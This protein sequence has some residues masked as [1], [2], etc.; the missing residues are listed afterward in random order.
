VLPTAL[1]SANPQTSFVSLYG[2]GSLIVQHSSFRSGRLWRMSVWMLAKTLREGH[3]C[4]WIGS[5]VLSGRRFRTFA[6]LWSASWGWR[7]ILP[8]PLDL[9]FGF[10]SVWVGFDSIGESWTN[11]GFGHLTLGAK[12]F[13][14][15]VL[16]AH[17]DLAGAGAKVSSFF[18][19]E[20]FEIITR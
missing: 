13:D 15:V 7:R 9:G 12:K 11:L 3:T 4:L 20:F 17:P 14:D 10:G 19:S 8:Y 6:Q 18:L 5:S 2:E 16:I 1:V